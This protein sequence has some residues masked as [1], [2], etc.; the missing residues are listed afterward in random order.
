MKGESQRIYWQQWISSSGGSSS[1]SS[2]SGTRRELI[3]SSAALRIS[4]DSAKAKDV[5]KLLRDTLNLA[6]LGGSSSEHQE[7][8]SSSEISNNPSKGGND[9]LVL[10]GTLYSLPRDYVQFEHEPIQ[11]QQQQPYSQ[12]NNF[13]TIHSP[14]SSSDPFHVVKTL[15]PEDNP[16]QSRDQMMDHL[17]NIQ[18]SAPKGG[19]RSIISPKIQWYFVPGGVAST[20]TNS[21][22]PSCI[23][24]D[25]YCTSMEEEFY[26]ED[27]S[28]SDDDEDISDDNS[29]DKDKESS[30]PAG[31]DTTDTTAE[32]TFHHEDPDLLFSR[33]PFLNKNTHKEEEKEEELPQKNGGSK[34]SIE[35]RR[36]HNQ[37]VN[38]VRRYTQLYQSQFANNISSDN[39]RTTCVSGYLL[40]KSRVDPHVWRRVHCVLTDDY[41]WYVTR[42][43]YSSTTTSKKISVSTSFPYRMAKKHGRISLGRA[44]LLE[45]N[46][47]YK[48]SP[49]Y[50]IS[51]AF[52]MV[53][54]RGI[55]HVFR[56]TNRTVQ[57]N[58]IDSL[59]TK[60][61]E[62]FENSL[63]ANAEL[64]TADESLARNKRLNSIAVQPLCY[65]HQDKDVDE[66][67]IPSSSSFEENNAHSHHVTS[68]LRLGMEI[69][70]YRERCRQVQAILPAKQPIVVI[71]SE[72]HTPMKQRLAATNATDHH[73]HHAAVPEPPMPSYEPFDSE[74]KKIVSG[75]WNYATGLLGR[76]TQ[77][78]ME[79]QT[80]N[81][82]NSSSGSGRSYHMLSRSLETL[83]KHVDYVI[84][85][86]HRTLSTL[87]LF[88]EASLGGARQQKEQQQNNSHN[89]I[90]ENQHTP[91][92]IDLFDS[93]LAELQSVVISPSS[94][95]HE[96]GDHMISRP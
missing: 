93:L 85:G 41:L 88:E 43:P 66:Q 40:K 7:S 26:H 80:T 49:L 12:N 3:T 90:V 38:E 54:S 25:G 52:E 84:T 59:S 8:S 11:Q 91:P 27:S 64:I 75:T 17:R 82:N 23:E 9:S 34:N 68:V 73:Q 28:D 79:V 58:W 94:R 4:Q 2:S 48:R 62:S 53:S 60:I 29:N 72:N 45:P 46:S 22:I 95:H 47:E 6:S 19:G 74:T 56:A 36:R 37:H 18:D 87:G 71:T 39:S 63:M 65:H 16:L 20:N 44:L 86:Q 35:R 30:L 50:R 1:A 61:M 77:V 92:P 14:Q 81:S 24:L 10:V 31:E 5:T 32:T 55:S 78:A 89:T 69:S 70:E 33:C 67:R 13:T 42:V 96:N 21:P 76:A 51:H 57:Q 83:C 15:A